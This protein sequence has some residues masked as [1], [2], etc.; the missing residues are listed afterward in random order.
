MP[1]TRTTGQ[2]PTAEQ[3]REQ[4]LAAAIEEFAANGYHATKTAAIAERAGISQPYIYALFKDKKVLFMAVQDVVGERIGDAFTEAWQEPASPEE[5][6][7]AIGLA[8]RAL[9]SNQSLMRCQLQG[10][11]ASSDPDIREHMRNLYMANFERLQK[12]T[13]LDNVT[14]AR[15]I[16]TGVLLNIGDALEIPYDYA[17]A[18]PIG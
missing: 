1:R 11:A 14:V 13:G 10:Y 4:V 2:R 17:F 9:M 5:G 3:R 15:F 6:L 16:A 18:P 12:M 8:F 7:R